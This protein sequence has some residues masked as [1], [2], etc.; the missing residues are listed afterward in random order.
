[1][2]LACAVVAGAV[3]GYL[4]DYGRFLGDGAMFYFFLGGAVLASVIALVAGWLIGRAFGPRR[5]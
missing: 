1:M 5:R 2:A 3:Q 4:P